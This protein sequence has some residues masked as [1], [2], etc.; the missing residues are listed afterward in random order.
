MA[1]DGD[2]HTAAFDPVTSCVF[3]SAD[4]K[5]RERQL[6]PKKATNPA[7]PPRQLDAEPG[8]AP[9]QRLTRS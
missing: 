7:V 5:W 3:V 2:P 9:Q 4:N 1:R 8:P 6:V